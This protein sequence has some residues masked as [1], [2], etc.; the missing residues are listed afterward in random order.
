VLEK[1]YKNSNDQ[2]RALGYR[3]AIASIKNFPKK[4]E[5]LEV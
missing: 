1:V 4:I 3:K 2:W 5:T